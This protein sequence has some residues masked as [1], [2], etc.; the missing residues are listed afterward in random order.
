MYRSC[1]FCSAELGSNESIERFP[2]GRSLAF[3]AAKG[4]LWAVCPKCAR[5]NLAP[6]EER[7]E[8]IEDAERLFRDTLMRVQRENIGLAKLPDGTRLVRV[9]QALPGELAVWRYGGVLRRRRAAHLVGVGLGM[10][11]PAVMAG[12]LATGVALGAAAGVAVGAA[13]GSGAVSIP[14]VYALIRDNARNRGRRLL[15]YT[16]VDV[17]AASLRRARLAFTFEGEASVEVRARVPVPTPYPVA[18]GLEPWRYDTVVLPPEQGRTLLR[19]GMV[20]LNAPLAAG[21][22]VRAAVDLLTASGS[23]KDYLRRAAADRAPVDDVAAERWARGARRLA[24]EMAVHDDLE[25]EALQGELAAL[26]AA[27]RQAEEIARIA[28]ALPDDLPA[29]EPPRIPLG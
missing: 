16:G 7:W 5:W 11:A 29:D 9:G 18:P 3:D 2:V 20:V 15:P 27:W 19:R 12:M 8:A 4:R 26:E 21:D 24:L 1:I 22:Q 23:A 10:A 28:D 6:I 13:L 17:D 25:R 14:L